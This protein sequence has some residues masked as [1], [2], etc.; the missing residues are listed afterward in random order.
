[1]AILAGGFG[2]RLRGVVGERQKVVAEVAG[3]P[4]LAHLLDQVERW[5]FEDVVLCVGHRADEVEEALG[6]AH[7]RLRLRYSR[8][9]CALG[10]AGALRLALPL[11]R[12]DTVLV[13][14]GDSY[15]D[16]DVPAARAWHA[17]REAEAT[18]V[19]VE[20]EDTRRYGRVE[21]DE[22]GL[23]RRFEEKQ[24]DGRP[25]WINA[26]I[27]LLSRALIGSIP[28]AVALSLERDV[29][30]GWIGRG[31]HGWR[32]RARFLDIG[33]P[34]SYADASRFFAPGPPRAQP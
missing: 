10:T 3:R 16:A 21:I 22:D 2:T 4:F 6:A 24:E 7:G 32:T 26:G 27:Y 23:V 28:P 14:N 29:L 31:L 20:M 13:M 11:L 5:G 12:G 9:D 25:G 33:T 8:E 19:L 34:R 30:P 18:I 17:E 15:C 1:V